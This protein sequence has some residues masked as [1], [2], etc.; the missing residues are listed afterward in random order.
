MSA[1]AKAEKGHVALNA[2]MCYNCHEIVFYKGL[3][4]AIVTDVADKKGVMLIT[5]DS[6]RYLRVRKKHFTSRPVS[7]GDAID[8][9]YIDSLAALQF[10]DCYEAALSVLDYSAKTESEI[11]KKLVMSGYV[12]PAADAAVERLKQAGLV[13]DSLIAE[14]I[15]K[16][17]AAK[18]G[19]YAIKRKLRQKGIAESVSEDALESLTD[20]Q[21]LAAA[22]GLI[23][24]YQ[25][26]YAD[27]SEREKRNK[28]SQ[29]LARRGFS[30]SV[31]SEALGD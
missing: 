18:S 6:G 24:K 22:K 27:L 15:V 4:M 17:G 10:D 26:K 8:R 13:N 5:L 11:R 2:A 23:A 16:S 28:L 30:W 9:S 19:A 12:K 31:I 7:V 29:A 20:E 14:R 1:G 21:Q 3:Y 25:R